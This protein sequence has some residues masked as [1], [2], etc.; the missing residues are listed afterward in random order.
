MDKI[1]YPQI[2]NI[3]GLA[4]Q[5]RMNNDELHDLVLTTTGSDSIKALSKA[6][7]IKVIDRLNQMLG[8]VKPSRATPNQIWQINKLA[9]ELGWKSDPRR[10][11]RF[12]EKQQGVSHTS[13]L[14]PVQASKVIEALKAMK[15]REGVKPNA[16]RS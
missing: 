3:F 16:G 7:G 14:S 1:T 12:L 2:K 10:L 15:R 13:Y 11:R 9:E 4:R 5:A 6:Q 8:K